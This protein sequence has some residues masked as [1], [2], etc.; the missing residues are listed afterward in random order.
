MNSET[1]F[2]KVLRG[3]PVAVTDARLMEM[4]MQADAAVKLPWNDPAHLHW[5][6][7]AA[8]NELASLRATDRENN[9]AV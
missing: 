6:W 7:L 2:D 9:D 3:E 4:R 5:H 8:L 1:N